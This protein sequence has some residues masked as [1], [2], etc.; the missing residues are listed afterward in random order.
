M[1]GCCDHA[2]V[3][4]VVTC[5]VKP[6]GSRFYFP[7]G[8]AWLTRRRRACGGG[9]DGICGA[10]QALG[11]EAQDGTLREA[12]QLAEGSIGRAVSLLS[13]PVL[14]LRQRVGALLDRLPGLHR[15]YRR[16][17]AT[18]QRRQCAAEAR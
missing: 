14:A 16:R 1:S 2:R 5:V 13:G 10:A 15:R 3:V 18:A 12:A 11:R 6:C 4:R 7:R 17:A 9:D 8:G